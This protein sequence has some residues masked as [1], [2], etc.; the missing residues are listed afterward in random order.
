[1]KLIANL[2]N[3]VQ[4]T[5]IVNLPNLFANC[6]VIFKDELMSQHATLALT[7]QPYQQVQ[8]HFVLYNHELTFLHT[9]GHKF[10]KF[11]RTKNDLRRNT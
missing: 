3:K 1:M 7:R 5:L 2:I 10:I 9:Q 4:H 6:V 8:S 11:S